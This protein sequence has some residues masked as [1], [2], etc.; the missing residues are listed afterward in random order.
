[1]GDMGELQAAYALERKKRKD[2]D[3]QITHLSG[4]RESLLTSLRKLKEQYG[5]LKA[6]VK[7]LEGNGSVAAAR[8]VIET[9]AP[10]EVLP[11]TASAPPAPDGTGFKLRRCSSALARGNVSA[12]SSRTQKMPRAAQSEPQH[13]DATVGPSCL[14]KRGQPLTKQ[15]RIS[16]EAEESLKKEFKIKSYAGLEKG[17]KRS[18]WTPK[19]GSTLACDA[20]SIRVALAEGNLQLDPT[21]SQF[22]QERFLCVT[23]G[24][25]SASIRPAANLLL[26]DAPA[27]TLVPADSKDS[28]SPDKKASIVEASGQGK[29]DKGANPAG[30]ERVAELASSAPAEKDAKLAQQSSAE[31]ESKLAAPASAGED[32]KLAAPSTDL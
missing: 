16:F 23:C 5:T 17:V 28:T 29:G 13:R 14:A 25:N 19:A 6:H 26:A 11:S 31:Q 21:K 1:M 9:T 24:G 22:M 15:Q 18:L 10:S 2:S 12:P 32:A 3:N 20:C 8:P 4:A 27:A 7:K 30:G